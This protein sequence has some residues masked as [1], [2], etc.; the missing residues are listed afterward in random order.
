MD[1]YMK[2]QNEI[3]R[4]LNRD[5]TAYEFNEDYTFRMVKEE[6]FY[7]QMINLFGVIADDD[8]V[9]AVSDETIYEKSFNLKDFHVLVT[10]NSFIYA[11]ARRGDFYFLFYYMFYIEFPY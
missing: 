3:R 10:D 7:K 9:K 1:F 5:I 2:N 6:L 8:N 4:D 11:S